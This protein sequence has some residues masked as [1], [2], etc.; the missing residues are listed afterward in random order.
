MNCVVCN[1]LHIP[2]LPGQVPEEAA[3]MS[4]LSLLASEVVNLGDIF[5]G[6]CPPHKRIIDETALLAVQFLE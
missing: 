6:L 3:V 5:K 1:S 4:L 2:K